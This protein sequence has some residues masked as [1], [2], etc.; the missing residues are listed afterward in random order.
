[1]TPRPFASIGLR[2]AVLAI[3]I[4]L[5]IGCGLQP[6]ARLVEPVGPALSASL[7]QP[8]PAAETP[9]LAQAA[10]LPLGALEVRAAS[11]TFEQ[12]SLA[13]AAPGL[14]TVRIVNNDALPHDIVFDDGTRLDVAPGEQASALVTIPA[15][16]ATFLCVV[17]G[18]RDAGM[19]GQVTVTE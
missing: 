6:S 13:V 16:G 11:L 4:S 12:R 17:A 3:A 7:A 19:V 5:L 14:Y 8:D 10:P 1:M 9:A 18:H 2:V 15:E